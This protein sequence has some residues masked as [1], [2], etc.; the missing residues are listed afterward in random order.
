[1]I[2]SNENT[3]TIKHSQLKSNPPPK[4]KV[5]RAYLYRPNIHLFYKTIVSYSRQSPLISMVLYEVILHRLCYKYPYTNQAFLSYSKV[6][7]IA[8]WVGKNGHTHC[9]RIQRATLFNCSTGNSQS[10]LYPNSYLKSSKHHT[11]RLYELWAVGPY[12][13]VRLTSPSSH[14]SWLA[15]G[16]P[17]VQAD[18]ISPSVGEREQGM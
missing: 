13:P 15:A 11:T 3:F 1:M 2:T 6:L 5:K 7:Y 16:W 12:G 8:P 10:L 18:E 17:L 14:I 9:L 4:K